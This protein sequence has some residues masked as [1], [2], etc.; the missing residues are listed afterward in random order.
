MTASDF[1]RE[2][3]ALRPVLLG[4][5]R[6][7]LGGAAEAEDAVQEALLKLWGMA[8]ELRLPLGPLA[9]V[10]VRNMCV[11]R[12]RRRRATV[13]VDG[14]VLSVPSAADSG[15]D[16]DAVYDRVMR[17]VDSL[18]AVEQVVLR[19]RHV[20]GMEF[21]DIARLTG[22]TEAAVRKAL[23]RARMAVRKRFINDTEI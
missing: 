2:A 3:A 19:L 9:K 10:V 13:C 23:S 5:A 7:M 22:S 20:D 16:S 12:L 11:D 8:G 18:P 6:G 14:A 1:E 4:E 15:V 21:A 17:V